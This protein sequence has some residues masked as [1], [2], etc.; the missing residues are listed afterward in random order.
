M[1][2]ERSA[3]VII[4]RRD[5]GKLFYLLLRHS[6]GHWDFPKGHIEKGETSYKAALREA[7]EESG[8]N[9]L[10]L[11]SRWKKTIRYQ[12]RWEGEWRLKFVVFFLGRTHEKR[13]T[14]S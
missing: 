8:L 10:S 2:V 13:I 12:Y 6:A 5:A 4:F 1:R 3:G 11:V 9:D 7:E 14:L